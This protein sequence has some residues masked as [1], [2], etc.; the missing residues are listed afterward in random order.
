MA[1]AAVGVAKQKTVPTEWPDGSWGFA[2]L[3]LGMRANLP[4]GG[5]STIPYLSASVGA[6]ALAA[7]AT[8]D[9]GQTKDAAI[10]GTS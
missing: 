8:F 4:L 2:H 7:S 5:A 10:S 1:F 6:R 9:Q 3:E